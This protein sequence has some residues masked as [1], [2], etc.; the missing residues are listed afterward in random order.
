M[1]IAQVT[2]NEYRNYG[3][4]LQ[5]YALQQTLK[6]FADF[7]EVLWFD[8]KNFWVEEDAPH[9]M[10]QWDPAYR[11]NQI[12]PRNWTLYEAVRTAK[13]KEFDER[14]IKTR[15]NLPYIEEI[16]DE[17]DFF[18]IGSDQVWHPLNGSAMPP[19]LKFFPYFPRKK[20][21]AYAA[22]I[23]VSEIP[24]AYKEYYRQG[25]AGFDYVSVRE[26]GAIKLIENLGLKAPQLVLDPVFLLTR[27]EWLKIS[28]QPSWFNEKYQR[29]YI[30][31]YYLRNEPPPQVKI[32]ASKLNL[33]VINLMDFNNFNHYTVGI[34]EWIFLM[35]NASLV[36]SNSFHGTS[37]AII[38]K[39]PFIYREDND[40]STKIIS[41]RL[42][43]L[44]KT[45]GLE[46][47]FAKIENDYKIDSP[48]E[49]DF[50]TRDKILPQEREKAFKFLA[51][52][53]S[54]NN[55]NGGQSIVTLVDCV[56]YLS[57]QV[58]TAA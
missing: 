26:E 11:P 6:K 42:P 47:R 49:I 30:F 15:F 50:S 3:N 56:E 9:A 4:V 37:F 12:Y 45:F 31:T 44:L 32:I 39:R 14:Y 35:M 33:P 51:D 28:R 21:I 18:V 25:I 34:E 10:T 40:D 52:A 38:F 57:S 16:G 1:R 19:S 22:S 48:L 20:R 5:K 23:G 43:S 55:L 54:E 29:G 13:F 2:Y 17:Y 24:D 36:F 58:Y 41:L 53:L 27:D 7:T 8:N 46:D